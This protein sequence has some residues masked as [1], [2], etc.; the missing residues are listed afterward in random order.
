MFIP[1]SHMH[2]KKKKKLEV[3]KREEQMDNTWLSPPQLEMENLGAPGWLSCLSS[4]MAQVMI[5]QLVGLSP[6]L[7]SELTAWSL[8][9][10][11]DSVSPSLCPSPTHTLS[12]SQNNKH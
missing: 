12:L 8:E 9:P 10:A 2:G 5:S 1:D 3:L 11:S 6:T 4:T 7:G